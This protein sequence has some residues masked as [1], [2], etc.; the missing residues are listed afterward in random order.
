LKEKVEELLAQP[1]DVQ[2]SLFQELAIARTTACEALALAQPL[3]DEKKSVKLDEAT[4]ALMLQ[5]VS[6][7][8]QGVKEMVLAASRIEKDAADKISIKVVNLI[9]MQIVLAIND[10]CGTENLEL[11]EAIAQ[12]IDERVRLPLNDRVNP[13]IDLEILPN[14]RK[15]TPDNPGQ[16]EI[17]L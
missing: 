16:I 5:T 6:Q 14:G 3:W 12:A 4:K 2:I 15:D 9:V 1:H 8:M 13:V 17:S 11:A 7:A 10:V